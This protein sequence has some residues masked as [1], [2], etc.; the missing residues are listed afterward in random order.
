MRFQNLRP[1]FRAQRSKQQLN[2]H[3]YKIKLQFLTVQALV[4]EKWHL[5][6]KTTC[7]TY[8]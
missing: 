2:R 5:N 7:Q 1:R 3:K 4:S 8:K 6:S